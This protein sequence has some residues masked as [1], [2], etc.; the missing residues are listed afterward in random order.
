MSAAIRPVHAA[1]WR[2]ANGMASSVKRPQP[3]QAEQVGLHGID[4]V[5]V[6]AVHVLLPCGV[7]QPHAVGVLFCRGAPA[8]GAGQFQDGQSE[9]E[10]R[11]E[12]YGPIKLLASCL[13]RR[14][15]SGSECSNARSTAFLTAVRRANTPLSVSTNDRDSQGGG[16]RTAASRRTGRLSGRAPGCRALP[17]RHSSSC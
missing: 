15:S 13:A 11:W 8:L 16:P 17:R 9:R 6:D 3:K 14:M 12:A 5:A 7:E 2:P 4:A 10:R 1:G